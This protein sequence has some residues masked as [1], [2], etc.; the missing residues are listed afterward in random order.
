VAELT[1]TEAAE[2]SGYTGRTLRFA[3]ARGDLRAKKRGP[4]WFVTEAALEKWTADVTKHQR[5]PKAR[6]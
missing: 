1:I 2:R 6:K 3:I 5:G 4:L